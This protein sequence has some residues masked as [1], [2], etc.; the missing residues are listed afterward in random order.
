[1]FVAYTAKIRGIIE[2]VRIIMASFRRYLGDGWLN[3]RILSI[4]SLEAHQRQPPHRKPGL[5]D[6]KFR[7]CRK[8]RLAWH[9]DRPVLTCPETQS[10][11]SGEEIDDW[12]HESEVDRTM[13]LDTTYMRPQMSVGAMHEPALHCRAVTILTIR[14]NHHHLNQL[15]PQSR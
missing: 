10:R 4:Q 13:P 3:P 11:N 15:D 8:G 6:F 12:S 5:L 1:M 14:H 7:D 9:C 2:C